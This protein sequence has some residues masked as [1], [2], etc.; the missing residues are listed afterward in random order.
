MNKILEPFSMPAS[1]ADLS[2]H[3][4]LLA[5][6]GICQVRKDIKVKVWKEESFR[7]DIEPGYSTH[8][9]DDVVF[10]PPFLILGGGS[11]P[12]DRP[13]A[14]SEYSDLH[15]ATKRRICCFLDQDY[16]V[17]WLSFRWACLVMYADV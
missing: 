9:V 14:G 15:L 16:S 5:V 6:A 4:D 7:G 2:F 10:E 12:V 11:R 8:V 13:Q 3:K 17:S 1:I